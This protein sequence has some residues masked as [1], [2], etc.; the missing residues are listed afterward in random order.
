[1]DLYRASRSRL[2]PEVCVQLY[3]TDNRGRLTLEPLMAGKAGGPWLCGPRTLRVSTGS[4][5]YRRGQY[6]SY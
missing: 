5:S 3:W 6:L 2:S 4:L 1:M